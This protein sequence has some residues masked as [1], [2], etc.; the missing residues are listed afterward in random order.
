M[1]RSA[2]LN[3]TDHVQPLTRAA[4]VGDMARRWSRRRPWALIFKI[5]PLHG[6]GIVRCSAHRDVGSKRRISIA[7]PSS[8]SPA[9]ASRPTGRCSTPG[10]G[11]R[12]TLDD[13]SRAA[14]R[15]PLTPVDFTDPKLEDGRGRRSPPSTAG[16]HESLVDR[17][18]IDRTVPGPIPQQVSRRQDDPI[19]VRWDGNDVVLSAVARP[20]RELSSSA[21]LCRLSVV[22][23][24][25]P[26]STRHDDSPECEQPGFRPP[27]RAIRSTSRIQWSGLKP[28][29]NRWSS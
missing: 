7:S 8:G 24:L 15:R 19:G 29:A 2:G 26:A 14:G 22:R 5:P 23:S 3:G 9:G 10:E 1:R 17:R 16:P 6:G 28:C 13:D 18:S 20:T 21:R 27:L 4:V 11:L 12:R 25:V